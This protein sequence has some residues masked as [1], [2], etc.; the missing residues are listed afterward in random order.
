MEVRSWKISADD[1]CVP[2][3]RKEEAKEVE[4]AQNPSEMRRTG[5]FYNLVS[6]LPI[7][8]WTYETTK[9]SVIGDSEETF[10]NTCVTWNCIAIILLKIKKF[11]QVSSSV[12]KVLKSWS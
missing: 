4:R 7:L 6:W 1:N 5:I 10:Q 2:G 3:V 9:A 11:I 8:D 12:R